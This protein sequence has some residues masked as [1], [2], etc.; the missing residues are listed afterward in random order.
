MENTRKEKSE[1]NTIETENE[2]PKI[3]LIIKVSENDSPEEEIESDKTE[4]IKEDNG[5]SVEEQIQDITNFINTLQKDIE[6]RNERDKYKDEAIQRMSKQIAD[7]EKGIFEKIK[8]ELINEI[9]SFYDL[10]SNFQRKFKSIEN[11]ELQ[12]EIDFLET[13]ISNMLFN[14][15]IDEIDENIGGDINRDF[16]RI[17]KKVETDNIE[18]NQKIKQ[19]VKKGFIWNDKVIRKQE[20]I[21]TEFKEKENID[22]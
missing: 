14:N 7:F 9:I 1:G 13:E 4:D 2:T 19:I 22:E 17:K 21:I 16:H 18:E 6:V 3:K 15:S 11:Q 12:N 10:L 5:I 20:V 8:K